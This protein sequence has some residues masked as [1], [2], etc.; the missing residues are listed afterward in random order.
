MKRCPVVRERKNW[1]NM[2]KLEW[3][4]CRALT[5]DVT[6]DGRRTRRPKGRLRRRWLVW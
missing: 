2:E 3:Q 5:G 6:S 4:T 1:K